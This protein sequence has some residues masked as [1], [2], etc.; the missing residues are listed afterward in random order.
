MKKNPVLNL[1]CSP[2]PEIRG[3]PSFCQVM[4]D[5]PMQ[6]LPTAFHPWPRARGTAKCQHPGEA[7]SSHKQP[8]V[9]PVA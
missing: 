6:V 8:A 3:L 2:R 1:D 9:L 4:W 7:T 5:P